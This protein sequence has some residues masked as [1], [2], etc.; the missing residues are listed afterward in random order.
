MTI[1]RAH[2]LLAMGCVA[3]W[4]LVGHGQEAFWKAKNDAGWKAAKANDYS[5]AVKLLGQA[6]EE[7]EK[8]GATDPRLALS[9]ANLAWVLDRQGEHDAADELTRRCQEILENNKDAKGLIVARTLNSL[10]LFQEGRQKLP[11]AESLYK[12]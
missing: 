7:A 3:I 1:R 2:W 4:P 6:V 8:L 10:A 5:Q 9:L 12:R 11:Q